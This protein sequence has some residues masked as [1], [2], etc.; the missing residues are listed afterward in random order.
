VLVRQGSRHELWALDGEPVTKP[1]HQ[2]MNELTARGILK[3]L[4]SKL[5]EDWWLE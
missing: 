3:R 5:G 2:E 4:E 1:R